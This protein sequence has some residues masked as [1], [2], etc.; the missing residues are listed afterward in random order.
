M[1]AR[2]ISAR[3]SNSAGWE[4][5]K[6][7]RIVPR[8]R[9]LPTPTTI[10]KPGKYGV[11][12]FAFRT[13]P[14]RVPHRTVESRQ[15]QIQCLAGGERNSIRADGNANYICD[16]NG[17]SDARSRRHPSDGFAPASVSVQG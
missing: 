8:S 11:V 17:H 1:E 3:A 12:R 7:S 6:P 13:R 10:S 9:G 14:R 2:A 15:L 16:A 5:S 4:G